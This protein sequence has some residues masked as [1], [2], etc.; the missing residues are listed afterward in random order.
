MK[1]KPAHTYPD[2]ATHYFPGEH[3]YLPA[4]LRSS[5]FM[6]PLSWGPLSW[7]PPQSLDLGRLPVI[8][9]GV[10]GSILGP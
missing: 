1:V 2:T 4:A 7:G 6:G 8:G 9:H 3:G 10:S 5:L